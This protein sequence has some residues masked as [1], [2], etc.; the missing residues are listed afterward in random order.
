MAL[1]II[2]QN[3]SGGVSV[4]IPNE[5]L[6]IFEVASKDV[7][8]GTPYQIIDQSDLPND[9]LF[10]SAWVVGSGCVLE[11]LE[12]CK[13]IGH[14]IRRQKRAHE[15]APLD[16]VIAK[17]IPGNDLLEAESKRQQVRNKYAAI[18]EAINQASS[19]V[20]IKI[21]LGLNSDN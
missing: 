2:Y 21:A 8:A 5:E 12:K 18:Q 13:L 16:D 4:I 15:F 19:S 1:R 11:D 10:R 3:E 7:P 14:D 9:R 6:P 17:Q 20:E